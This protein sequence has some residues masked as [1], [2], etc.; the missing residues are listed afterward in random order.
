MWK[1]T[2]TL[3]P[4]ANAVPRMGSSLTPLFPAHPVA[5]GLAGGDNLSNWS[6]AR[7]RALDGLGKKLHV[8]IDLSLAPLSHQCGT[9]GAVKAQLAE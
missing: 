5:G 9:I 3:A 6:G 7:G 8:G 2:T 1:L 4:E